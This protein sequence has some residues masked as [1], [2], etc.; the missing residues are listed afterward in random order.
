MYRV[1][2][3]NDQRERQA[4]EGLEDLLVLNATCKGLFD[5]HHDVFGQIFRSFLAVMLGEMCSAFR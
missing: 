2:E 5:F 4:R 3:S 1:S